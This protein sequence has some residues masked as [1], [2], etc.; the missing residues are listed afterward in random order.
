MPVSKE[1]L[2]FEHSMLSNKFPQGVKVDDYH[3]IAQA[4]QIDVQN[5]GLFETS[6]PDF[7]TY[8][9]GVKPEDL[10]PSDD[11]YVY[12]IVRVL[13]GI[14]LNKFGPLDFSKPSVLKSAL[15]LFPNQTVYANHEDFIGNN[16]GVIMEA[17]YEGTRTY[18]G[19]KVPPGINVRMRIDGKAQP[20]LARAVMADPPEVH[21]V[22]VGVVFEWE[23]SH[24]KMDREE[25]FSKLGSFDKEGELIRRVVKKILLIQELSFVNH[26][27]DPYAKVLKDNKISGVGDSKTRDDLTKSQFNN[28]K[29]S[30]GMEHYHDYCSPISMEDFKDDT[31]NKFNNHK[32]KINMDDELLKFLRTSLKMGDDS[33]QTAVVAALQ[34]KLPQLILDGTELSTTKD[35]LTALKA[36]YPDGVVI[37]SAED[38][39]KIAEHEELSKVSN[40]ALSAVR[41]EA[42]RLYNLV[43]D[44]KADDAILKLLADSNY[45][46]VIAMM[47]QYKATA[48]EKF[49]ATCGKCGSKDIS[50]VSAASGNQGVIHHD[51]ETGDEEL[52]EDGT[53]KTGDEHVAL[54][55]ADT[56]DDI[57]KKKNLQA[58]A[59]PSVHS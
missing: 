48:E 31:F 41:D 54:S 38:K 55:T 44:N 45:D 25:F 47:N 59:A 57:M 40:K 8:Y 20:N 11:E 1:V 18:D 42:I 7:N 4:Q 2:H 13:S 17:S 15:N 27:A 53:P 21:S 43:T 10:A 26:G 32:T 30:E 39:T 16:V 23:Q 22:S 9:P 37:L 34:A 51:N 3:K 5:F 6:T 28:A 52:N 36:K 46:T 19:V 58:K 35:E 12:P 49:T 50:R 14:I 29:F 24:A 56:I 33:D